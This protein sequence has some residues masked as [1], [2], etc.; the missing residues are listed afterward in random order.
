MVQQKVAYKF[1]KH[2]V[3]LQIHP[4]KLRGNNKAETDFK[5]IGAVFDELNKLPNNYSLN[6][7]QLARYISNN[8]VEVIKRRDI[9]DLPDWYVEHVQYRDRPQTPPPREPLQGSGDL[10]ATWIRVQQMTH[11]LGKYYSQPWYK[12][13]ENIFKQHDGRVYTGPARF[14]NRH[15]LGDVTR[16][17]IEMGIWDSK[18]CIVG[19][20]RYARTV[21]REYI[22]THQLQYDPFQDSVVDD[23][24]RVIFEITGDLLVKFELF[25]NN[26]TVKEREKKRREDAKAAAMAGNKKRRDDA[27]AKAKA[28]KEKAKAN[29]QAKAKADKAKAKANTQAKAKIPTPPKLSNKANNNNNNTPPGICKCRC[30]KGLTKGGGDSYYFMRGGKKVYCGK[31]LGVMTNHCTKHC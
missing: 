26:R 11:M 23:Q 13:D 4:D 15:K 1:F 27:K 17:M 22:I 25:I 21:N 28:D 20:Y 24:G 2:K 3:G 29:T 31:M 5:K 12:P 10:V 16:Q 14:L 7:K 6:K 19:N 9:K 30:K 8:V 18:A